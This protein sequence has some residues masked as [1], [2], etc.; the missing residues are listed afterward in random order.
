MLDRQQAVGAPEPL[1]VCGEAHQA[2]VWLAQGVQVAGLQVVLPAV[3][4]EADAM[5]EQRPPG[6]RADLALHQPRQPIVGWPAVQEVAVERQPA[7]EGLEK[8]AWQSR[9]AKCIPNRLEL[10]P[11]IAA[12]LLALAA[13]PSTQVSCAELCSVFT[14]ASNS[15]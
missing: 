10:V 4:V 7:A 11:A 6:G 15:R 9:L 8:S 12:V 2:R 13:H 1:E 5:V 14:A 3:E